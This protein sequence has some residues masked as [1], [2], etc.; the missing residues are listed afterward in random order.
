M[1]SNSTMPRYTKENSTTSSQLRVTNQQA[2]TGTA[3]NSSNLTGCSVSAW[4]SAR[5]SGVGLAPQNSETAGPVGPQCAK[6][7]MACRTESGLNGTKAPTGVKVSSL[8]RS[9]PK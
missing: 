4:V 3:N 6:S 7:V 1:F 8:S 9:K 5:I 2:A